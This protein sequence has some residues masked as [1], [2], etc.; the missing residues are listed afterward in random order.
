[1]SQ[2]LQAVITEFVARLRQDFAEEQAQDQRAFERRAAKIF[3]KQIISSRAGRPRNEI[4]TRAAEM[5]RQGKLWPQIFD[6]CLPANL[7]R[8]AR[9]MAKLQLRNAVR[10]RR[11]RERRARQSVLCDKPREVMREA[12]N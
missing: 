10:N 1:M 2:D 6:D 8:T 9:N 4:V 7:E 12:K 5:R 3:K 11:S